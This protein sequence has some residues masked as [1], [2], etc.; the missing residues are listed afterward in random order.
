M[1]AGLSYRFRLSLLK[2]LRKE[3]TKKMFSNTQLRDS[4][5][6]DIVWLNVI[7]AMKK[8]LKIR[9]LRSMVIKKRMIKLEIKRQQRQ[10]KMQQLRS[11][12]IKKKQRRK[13]EISV[14]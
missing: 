4:D 10:G 14:T 9:N 8:C 7:L 12:K 1:R 13:S 5:K 6:S 2:S 11:Q 3:F